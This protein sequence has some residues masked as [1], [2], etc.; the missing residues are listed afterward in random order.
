MAVSAFSG[1]LHPACKGLPA[2]PVTST[3]QMSIR[4]GGPAVI[5]SDYPQFKNVVL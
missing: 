5:S 1:P 2:N 4:F 3:N